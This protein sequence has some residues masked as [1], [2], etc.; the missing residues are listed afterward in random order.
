VRN[1]RIAANSESSDHGSPGFKEI[2]CVIDHPMVCWW[3]G[4]QPHA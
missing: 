1:I 4:D 3:C 2:R